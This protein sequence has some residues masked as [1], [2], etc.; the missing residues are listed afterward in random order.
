MVKLDRYIGVTVFVAILAVLGV[1]LGLALLFAFIDE[2]NDISAS[3]GIGDA[4]RFIF[5]TAPR[6]AYDMLPMAALIGCLVGLGTLASNSE[7]TIMRAA[8]VSLSRIVWAVMKP[9]LVLM[10]AGI[11]VGE[12]V[13]PW[14]E[15]IAQSG[16]ALAQGGGDSQSSKRGLWHRQGREYIHINAV[17]PNG[18]LYGVTRYRFD[19]QR[20]LESASFAKRARFETDHWQLEEVTTTLL[21]PREKRSEVVKLPTE[22]WDAQLSP[23]LLNTV[24]ME[25][26]ALSISGLWQYIHY[27][28]DQGLNNNRYWLAFWTKVL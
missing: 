1:I 22:R 26:E 24:V 6:R 14:T 11:L 28:A 10:V 25:P 12:Y 3:Y 16:R 18:V 21:H 27:L 4:L 8:G 19:E 15:N 13:A 7:L 17:Q 20:G 2:L 5:L 23:Q 9:M